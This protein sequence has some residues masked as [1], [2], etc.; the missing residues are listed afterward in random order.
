MTEPFD[1][2][3]KLDALSDEDTAVAREEYVRLLVSGAVMGAASHGVA[4]SDAEVLAVFKAS[5]VEIPFH[6]RLA[7]LARIKA[8]EQ[9][10]VLPGPLLDAP[11]PTGPEQGA[12]GRAR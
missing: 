1:P 9:G 4:I 11:Q 8:R 7:A 5:T 6:D 10:V 3:A 2:V 12:E